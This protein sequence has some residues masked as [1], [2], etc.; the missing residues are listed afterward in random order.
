MLSFYYSPVRVLFLCLQHLY[1]IGH[2][3]PQGLVQRDS[4]SCRKEHRRSPVAHFAPGFDEEGS[5]IAR[6]GYM[7]PCSK[8]TDCLVCGRH[9]LTSAQYRC[10]KRYILYDTVVTTDKGAITFVNTTGG[11]ADAFDPDLEE[12]AITG[13]T[14]IC[15]DIDVRLQLEP[16]HHPQITNLANPNPIVRMSTV[17]VQRG[18]LK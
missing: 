16:V 12:G 17:V 7:H 2:D 10:Q 14:G 9:P 4:I 13:K 5:P 8:H 11:S 18:V 6:S 3:N 1:H 15:V